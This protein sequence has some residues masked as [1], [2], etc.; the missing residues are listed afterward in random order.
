MSDL[1]QTIKNKELELAKLK[2]QND[3]NRIKKLSSPASSAVASD[4]EETNNTPTH[5][6][7]VV[8][9]KWDPREEVTYYTININGVT[10]KAL[11]EAGGEASD[12]HGLG[13]NEIKELFDRHFYE[14]KNAIDTYR[15]TKGS[16]DEERV[17]ET[18]QIANFLKAISQKNYAQADKYLQSTVESKLKNSI[19]KA[20]QNLK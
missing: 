14:I 5:D 8:S 4:D 6:I 1:A 11:E 16:E 12:L 13:S 3:Q 10:V 19:N 17:S 2:L 18:T 20:A 15:K 7:H 9:S